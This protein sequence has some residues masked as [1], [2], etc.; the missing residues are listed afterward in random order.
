V[1]AVAGVVGFGVRGEM[2]RQQGQHIAVT[3]RCSTARWGNLQ[4]SEMRI[5]WGLGMKRSCGGAAGSWLPPDEVLL[6]LVG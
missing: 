3:G 5:R 6:G 4:S 2:R 1:A